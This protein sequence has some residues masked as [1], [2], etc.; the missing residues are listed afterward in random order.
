MFPPE[1]TALLRQ[2]VDTLAHHRADR[3]EQFDC[4]R[5][6]M[7]QLTT[8]D[9]FYVAEFVGDDAVHYH[10]QYDGDTFDLPGSAAVVPGRTAAWVRL[11]RGTYRYSEDNGAALHAG[12]WQLWRQQR[13]GRVGGVLVAVGSREPSDVIC[14]RGLTHA[15]V[16]RARS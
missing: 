4:V 9:A 6:T 3:F 8:V 11:H 14:V 10:H 7:S 16:V 15:W 5:R 13:R 12:L 2:A 1:V